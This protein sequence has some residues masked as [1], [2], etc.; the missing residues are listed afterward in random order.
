VDVEVLP[1]ARAARRL[2]VPA[3][4]LRAEADAGRVPYLRA[5]A[6]YLFDLRALTNALARRA[7]RSSDEDADHDR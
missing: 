2:G 4:W 6:R 1:L 7:T 5:G 3:R